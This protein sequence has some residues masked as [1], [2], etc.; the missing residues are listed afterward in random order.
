MC[1]MIDQLPVGTSVPADLEIPAVVDLVQEILVIIPE[2]TLPYLAYL[3]R[4]EL[5]YHEF[6][7]YCASVQVLYSYEWQ[8][9]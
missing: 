4:Q 8:V 9:V 2:W 3:L 5:P 6:E 1:M 7:A